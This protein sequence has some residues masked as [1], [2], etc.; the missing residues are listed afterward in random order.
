MCKKN[1]HSALST[2]RVFYFLLLFL[3]VIVELS[4]ESKGLQLVKR[5]PAVCI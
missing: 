5:A 3:N 2:Q 1:R 4:F